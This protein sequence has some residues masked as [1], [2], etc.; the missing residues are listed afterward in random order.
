MSDSSSDEDD[1]D[2]DFVDT[3][4]S[5]GSK[6][7]SSATGGGDSKSAPVAELDFLSTL[8]PNNGGR[9][10][11]KSPG[12]KPAQSPTNKLASRLAGSQVG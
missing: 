7:E 9:D 5:S 1:D 11:S 3:Q 10:A 4:T 8:D 12:L 2:D 6:E